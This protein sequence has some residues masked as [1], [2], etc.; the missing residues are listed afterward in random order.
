[1]LEQI[2]TPELQVFIYSS[3]L[4]VQIGFEIL[5]QVYLHC[6]LFISGI[7]ICLDSFE[8]LK[9]VT[10]LFLF[11]SGIFICFYLYLYIYCFIYILYI[12]MVGGHSQI[13][14]SKFFSFACSF[15]PLRE[16]FYL[17]KGDRIFFCFYLVYIRNVFIISDRYCCTIF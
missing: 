2:S 14:F 5:K 7:F 6:F 11:I 3:I 17:F 15:A 1:M 16:S 10:A 9:Q 8:I 13:K 12:E 4:F